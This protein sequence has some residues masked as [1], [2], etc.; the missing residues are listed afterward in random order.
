MEP[1][2]LRRYLRA[3]YALFSPFVR[4]SLHIV[5]V[6]QM[7]VIHFARQMTTLKTID[8]AVK[9][10]GVS[11]RLLHKWMAEGKLKRWK[12]EG[13]RH[14]YVDLD[15]IKKLREPRVE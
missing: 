3:E 14:R 7:S 15:A 2:R 1:M 10:T 12:I 6:A 11:R 4:I 5:R 13:D 8:Q 9:A